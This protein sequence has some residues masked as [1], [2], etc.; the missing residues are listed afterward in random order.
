MHMSF[1]NIDDFRL[2]ALCQG[3]IFHGVPNGIDHCGFAFRF[4]VI[5]CLGKAV[6]VELFNEHDA[7]INTLARTPVFKMELCTKLNLPVSLPALKKVNKNKH[8]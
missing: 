4:N 3:V 2:S 7:K 6:C 1:K 5:G 8:I